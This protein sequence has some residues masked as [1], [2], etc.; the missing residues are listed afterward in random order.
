MEYLATARAAR[1]DYFQQITVEV[2]EAEAENNPTGYVDYPY[3][4][5][6]IKARKALGLG[7]KV[8]RL[9]GEW[10][11]DGVFATHD[12]QHGEVLINI[13]SL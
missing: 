12:G 5:A 1:T 9:S 3:T 11:H 13:A 8:A 10:H 2:A 4:L 7:G 6:A